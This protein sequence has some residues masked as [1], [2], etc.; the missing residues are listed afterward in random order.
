MKRLVLLLFVGL[1]WLAFDRMSKGSLPTSASDAYPFP[2]GDSHAAIA[3]T[4]SGEV[5]RWCEALGCDE[6]ALRSA[7]DA[8]GRSEQAVRDHLRRA[9]E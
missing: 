5:A 8:V 9:K 3:L 2:T 6:Q 1:G 7:V 4:D